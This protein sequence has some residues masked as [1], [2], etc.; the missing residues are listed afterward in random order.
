MGG[1]VELHVTPSRTIFALV[2]PVARRDTELVEDVEP[3]H[4]ETAKT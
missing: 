2:L 4:V 3:F 1:A